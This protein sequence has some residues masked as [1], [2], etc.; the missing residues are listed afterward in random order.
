MSSIVTD[1][2]EETLRP[3]D[4][5]KDKKPIDGLLNCDHCSSE[6]HFESD[7]NESESDNFDQHLAQILY[8]LRKSDIKGLKLL[9]TRGNGFVSD[10]LRQKIWPKLLNVSV[11]ETSPRPDTHTIE[12][13]PFYNQVVLDVNRSLK[14]FP[15]CIGESQRI[16]MQD[17]LIRLIMRVLVKNPDLHYFQGY[18]DICVTFLM[19]LGE[20]MAFYCL[21]KLSK[22]HFKVFMEKTMERTCDLMDIIPI[23]VKRENKALSDYLESAEVG[24]IFGLSWVIT[25]FSHVLPTYDDVARLFDFFIVS[26]SLMPLYLTVALV[27]Y[28]QNDILNIECDMPSIHHF[29]TRVP[30]TEELPIEALI[31]KAIELM[32]KHPPNELIKEQELAKKER[33]RLQTRRSGR[34]K[35]L[36]DLRYA[37]HSHFKL[38]LFSV[39]LFVVVFAIIYQFYWNIW[40]IFCYQIIYYSF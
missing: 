27:I 1:L 8:C 7:S 6:D 3:F 20:E 15:P 2:E 31:E 29:L 12:S 40:F 11:I 16:S 23:L 22:T 19:I 24:T 39:T 34:L 33:L 26:H 14:R 35:R 5:L 37:I 28:K 10:R 21:N 17:S 30:E 13:H 4:G 36:F 25:W 32:D 9:A 38:N 18:H